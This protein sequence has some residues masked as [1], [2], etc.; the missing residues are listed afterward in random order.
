MVSHKAVFL[1]LLYFLL[2][3]N[4]V[5]NIFEEL[6]FKLKLFADN[7]KLYSTYDIR[8]SQSDL[9]T[10]VNRLYE[11]SCI[12]QLQIATEKY[13]VCTIASR[14]QNLTHRVYGIN[15]HEFAH[16]FGI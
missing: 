5:G 3:I 11:W 4:D 2:F 13:F 1:D 16:V 9:K 12:K 10:A 15:S 6:D 7:I 14:R 8:G